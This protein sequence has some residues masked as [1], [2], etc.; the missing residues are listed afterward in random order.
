LEWLPERGAFVPAEMENFRHTPDGW[1][2][3]E[4]T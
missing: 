4:E 2:R 3:V 1:I